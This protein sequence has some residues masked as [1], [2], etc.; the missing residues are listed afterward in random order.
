M[1]G[2]GVHGIIFTDATANGSI[3]QRSIGAYRMATEWRR[4]GL[5]IQVIDFWSF[6]VQEGVE[7]VCLLLD[8]FVGSETLF[9][10]FSTT[11]MNHGVEALYD[12]F[13]VRDANSLN[14]ARS[15]GANAFS[16]QEW[17]L[18][19][20]R[21][22]IKA[23]NPRI[24]IVVGGAQ[25]STRTDPIGDF[26]MFGF[27]EVHGR[28]YIEWKLG[29][30]P[31]FSPKIVGDRNVRQLD[32]NSKAD[33]FE[34]TEA[35]TQ[36]E[37]ED[38]IQPN[39]TLPIEISRGCIFSCSFC[40]YP[41]NGKT[42]LDYLRST[43]VLRAE[44]MRNYTLYGTTRYIFVDDTYND[45]NDKLEWIN[46][47]RATLPFD[48]RFATYARLDLVAAKPE[49]ID[50]LKQNGLSH[51]FFGIETLNH[52]AGKSIGKGA[53]PEKLVD[54]LHRC[55]EAWGNDVLTTAGF[56]V[57]LPTETYATLEKWLERIV[58][59]FF[60][61]HVPSL[62][63]L[64]I[65][66]WKT[67]TKPWLS[68][69][70]RDPE[71]HGYVLNQRGWWTNYVLGTSQE[72]CDAL[73]GEVMDYIDATG[74]ASLAAHVAVSAEDYGLSKT[75]LVLAGRV[76][77]MTRSVMVS[78]VYQRYVNYVNDLWRLPEYD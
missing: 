67:S 33:G 47:I 3:W 9:V 19:I 21:D 43:E 62:S 72:G 12:P 1:T 6:L 7:T 39:E 11:F 65:S 77:L 35:Y 24:D 73:V 20:V 74:R 2:K 22:Y 13:F 69:L 70:D 8:K 78:A 71:Q 57:G 63:A 52:S 5:R 55:R 53:N 32:Y 29:R 64:T 61:I 48:L 44:F 56:I 46:E 76:G 28:D 68:A 10:G 18:R 26:R 58:D 38:C 54:T 36:W 27:G 60:P 45:T 31:F 16:T 4:M 41:L 42:K 37:A 40:S 30:K 59:P 34:F 17:K 25:A 66:N 49:Q 14:S 50:L 51:V 15:R 23:K 75:D